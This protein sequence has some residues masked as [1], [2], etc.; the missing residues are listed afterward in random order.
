MGDLGFSFSSWLK[1]PWRL[2]QL[3][4]LLLCSV[5]PMEHQASYDFHKHLRRS[6]RSLRLGLLACILVPGL[7]LDM[8]TFL[9]HGHDFRKCWSGQ[10][11][12][13]HDLL[14]WVTYV[15][16]F[17]LRLV[18]LSL[19]PLVDDIAF[20]R[21]AVWCDMF[22]VLSQSVA[23][24][25]NM[26]S[27]Q[28]EATIT[29]LLFSVRNLL[30]CVCGG[31]ALRATSPLD[32][33]RAIWTG[34]SIFAG[35]TVVAVIYRMVY[36]TIHGLKCSCG[37]AC[38]FATIPL[39]LITLFPEHRRKYLQGRALRYLDERDAASGA[40]NL[41]SLLNAL[42][43]REALRS[44]HQR[45]T[46]VSR[47]KL[48][49]NEMM[50]WDQAFFQGLANQPRMSLTQPC[51]LGSCDAWISHTSRDDAEAKWKSLEVWGAAFAE[52][53]GREP[54]LWIDTCC[55]QGLKPWC[56]PI[57]LKACNRLVVLC[58][59]AYS[60][61]LWCIVE[62]CLFVHV[63]GS[64]SNIDLVYILPEGCEAEAMS[65]IES[66]FDKLDDQACECADPADQA[67]LSELVCVAFGSLS[68]LKS[69]AGV[70]FRKLASARALREQSCV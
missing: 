28:D 24:I 6:K 1:W 39:L 19:A 53:H 38:L 9:S 26:H 32:A 29:H 36:L 8:A 3:S 22:V 59:P 17:Q 2:L 61:R 23:Q 58:G 11:V 16:C 25:S 67:A 10:A 41:A 70:L 51:A 49:L 65:A 48:S 60:S 30:F 56:L 5:V 57:F 66:V 7:L 35:L 45:F 14:L 62:M 64:V 52:K 68:A 40:V 63:G 46:C 54:L 47:D 15:V 13:W 18:F 50:A 44:A 12:S 37:V 4:L 69:S 55:G 31:W 33:Q 21:I 20:T 43:P 42:Q 34:V 27:G